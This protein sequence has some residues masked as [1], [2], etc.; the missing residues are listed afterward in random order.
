MNFMS[1]LPRVNAPLAFAP[2][3]LCKSDFT[4]L[5]PYTCALDAVH[6]N[7]PYVFVCVPKLWAS[8][9]RLAFIAMK[10]EARAAEEDKER[11]SRR[12]HEFN[13]GNHD[14]FPTGKGSLASGGRHGDGEEERKTN[15]TAEGKMANGGSEQR[16]KKTR[17]ELMSAVE[18]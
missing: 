8:L 12:S 11:R 1:V 6:H 17:D 9:N 7:G 13:D 15:N 10:D 14:K 18:E 5:R 16:W 2:L 3:N 4:V